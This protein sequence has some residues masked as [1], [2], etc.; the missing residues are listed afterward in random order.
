MAEH[1]ARICGDLGTLLTQFP[2]SCF[3]YLWKDT[4]FLTMFVDKVVSKFQTTWNMCVRR[5]FN[6]PYTTHTRFLPH[7]LEIS[8][9]TDQIYGRFLKMVKTME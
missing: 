3:S 6:L 2:R 1:F 7:I 9:V 5:I 8:T 4:S